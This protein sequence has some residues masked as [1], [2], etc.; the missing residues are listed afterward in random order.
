MKDFLTSVF[1]NVAFIVWVKDSNV[2]CTKGVAGRNLLNAFEDIVVK[3]D[4]KNGRIVGVQ[5]LNNV[6]LKFSDEIPES[7]HQRFRNCL[8][9]YDNY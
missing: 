6:K 2:I 7:L 3:N 5:M 9:F 1:N 4:I 8:T